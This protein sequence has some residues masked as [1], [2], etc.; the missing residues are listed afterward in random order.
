MLL[1]FLLRFVFNFSIVDIFRFENSLENFLF[2]AM[3]KK[4]LL[5]SSPDRRES[6]T[7]RNIESITA[8]PSG[9]GS[10][11]DT[12]NLSIFYHFDINKAVRARTI[13]ML[14]TF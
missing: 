8:L 14:K 12:K 4:P 13:S 10:I 9:E 6:S 7:I 3:D 2:F 1:I 5:T 11:T